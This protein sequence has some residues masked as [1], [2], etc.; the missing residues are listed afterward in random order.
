MAHVGVTL[1][2]GGALQ[3]L[4]VGCRP[5]LR[6]LK[7]A[8]TRQR[9]CSSPATAAAVKLMSTDYNASFWL[10]KSAVAGGKK[11]ADTKIVMKRDNKKKRKSQ[12]QPVISKGQNFDSIFVMDFEATCD[13]RTTGNRAK[14][15]FAPQEIIEIPCV[16]IDT[17]TFQAVSAFH[18]YVRPVRNPVL[19]HFCTGLTGIT[20]DTVDEADDFPVVFDRFRQW[21][22]SKTTNESTNYKTTDESTHSKE[23]KKRFALLCCGEWDFRRMLPEQCELSG[24]PLPEYFHQWI[25]VKRSYES[26]TGCFPRSLRHMLADLGLELEGRHHSGIDDVRNIA[27]IVRQLGLR[28]FVFEN[29][30]G[31]A[32]AAA[33][34]SAAAAHG[35]PR[36]SNKEQ[37]QLLR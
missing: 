23:K 13:K 4:H 26:A 37:Q 34:Q 31:K 12:E 7:S 16:E 24:V 17:R 8:I 21:I 10:Q 9:G 2:G 36:N 32:A 5:V 15:R 11:A 35:N 30:A 28:G 18:Q 29:T 19:T 14:D 27:R 1:R 22:E 3:S 25:N 6:I 33:S 20:Q